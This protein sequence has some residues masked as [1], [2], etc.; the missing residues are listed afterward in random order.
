MRH[1]LDKIADL[2]DANAVHRRGFAIRELRPLDVINSLRNELIELEEAIIA[3]D[4]T[5]Q[6][7]EMADVFAI[8]LHLAVLIENKDYSLRRLETRAIAKLDKRWHS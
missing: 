2:Y 8:A 7:E 5:H 3:K 6:A 1:L 4:R